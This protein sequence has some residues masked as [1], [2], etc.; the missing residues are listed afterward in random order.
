MLKHQRYPT[1]DHLWDFPYVQRTPH[2]T[3]LPTSTFG[4]G[5]TSASQFSADVPSISKFL[6][7]KFFA[8]RS[9]DQREEELLHISV[10]TLLGVAQMLGHTM[11]DRTS[12]SCNQ[13]ASL[14]RDLQAGSSTPLRDSSQR[15]LFTVAPLVSQPAV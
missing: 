14:L 13:D 9:D 1:A 12:I 15:H 10:P 5:H 8:E 11:E 3:G 7:P 6:D 2:G 4:T